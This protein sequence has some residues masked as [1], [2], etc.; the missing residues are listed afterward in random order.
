MTISHLPDRDL[1]VLDFVEMSI[2]CHQ[3]QTMLER[4]RCHPMSFSGSG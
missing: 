1:E 3:A 2:A 4:D